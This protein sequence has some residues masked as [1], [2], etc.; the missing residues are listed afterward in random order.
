MPSGKLVSFCGSTVN[1]V[2]VLDRTTA[3]VLLEADNRRSGRTEFSELFQQRTTSS[4][5]DQA[6][7]NKRWR[8]SVVPPASCAQSSPEQHS[9]QQLSL[10]CLLHI[11]HNNISKTTSIHPVKATVRG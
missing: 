4:C 8:R 9:W 11:D 10:D 5:L 6:A 3:E 7:S 2:Q 1:W